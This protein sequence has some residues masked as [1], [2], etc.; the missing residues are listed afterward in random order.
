[1]SK[2]LKWS[3]VSLATVGLL[4]IPGAPALAHAILL[5][6]HPADGAVLTSSPPKIVLE[7]GEPVLPDF[8]TAELLGGDG[9]RV[10]IPRARNDG[11]GPATLVIEPPPLEPG[12]Y[13][14]TWET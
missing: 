3:L 6:T 2:R 1:M 7:Y 9:R 4:L 13:R 8:T 5:R 12:I 10:P 14:L 11:G